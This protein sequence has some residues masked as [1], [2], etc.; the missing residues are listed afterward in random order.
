MCRVATSSIHF[1]VGQKAG[2]MGGG[3]WGGSEEARRATQVQQQANEPVTRD[4]VFPGRP[5]A[6]WEVSLPVPVLVCV[7]VCAGVCVR[8]GVVCAAR[9]EG[10][11]LRGWR[12]ILI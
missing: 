8:M 2:W 11:V 9:Q 10:K 3:C 7:C 12:M 5:F 4:G 1:L 6:F